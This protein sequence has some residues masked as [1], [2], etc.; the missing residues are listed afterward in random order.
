MIKIATYYTLYLIKILLKNPFLAYQE[1]FHYFIMNRIFHKKYNVRI[2]IGGNFFTI[3]NEHHVFYTLHEVFTW[4]LY[5]KLIW[6]KNVLDL[7]GFIGDTWVWLSQYNWNVSIYE[8]NPWNFKFIKINTSKCTNVSIYNWAVVWFN[9]TSTNK[10]Y[11]E[12]GDFNAWGKIVTHKTDLSI[13]IYDIKNILL[14]GQYDWLKMDIEWG[15]YE[16]IEYIMKSY[17]KF[18]FE[19]WYIEFHYYDNYEK[20]KFIK[21]FMKYL[22]DQLINIELEDVYGNLITQNEIKNLNPQIFVMYFSK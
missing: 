6:C 8:P 21:K 7:W 15:E 18:P 4:K 20:E 17:K 16:I 2:K 13:S 14:N 10:L 3:P 19:R 1:V 11:Y 12:W 5:K 22:G 9:N